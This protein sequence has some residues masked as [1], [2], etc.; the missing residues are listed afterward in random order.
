M[1]QQLQQHESF[2]LNLVMN[3]TF[4]PNG[5][6]GVSILNYNMHQNM[7]YDLSKQSKEKIKLT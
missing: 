5:Q 1:Q 6:K 2:G 3:G 4:N 7:E